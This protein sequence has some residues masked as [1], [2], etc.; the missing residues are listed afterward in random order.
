MAHTFWNGA[1]AQKMVHDRA[2]GKIKAACI[3]LS[4]VIKADISQAG[5][6]RYNPVSAKTGKASKTQK[7]IYNFTHSRP[8]SPPFKQTGHLRRSIAWEVEGLQGRVGTNLLYGRALELGTTR[9]APRPFILPAF[10][11]SRQ[12]LGQI[13]QGTIQPG[14]LPAIESNQ[15]RS[16]HLGAGARSAGYI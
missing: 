14:G 4:N 12:A 8:G 15:S 10:H 1:A 11:R 3:Y 5:T 9:M 16:G 13:I 2:S 6:L 7:T